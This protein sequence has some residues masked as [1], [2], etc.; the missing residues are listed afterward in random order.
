MYP[1]PITGSLETTLYQHNRGFECTL[2][3]VS[4]FLQGSCPT[5]ATEIQITNPLSMCSISLH[6]LYSSPCVLPP[7][8]NSGSK[9]SSNEELRCLSPYGDIY[10]K[11]QS[12]ACPHHV[13]STCRDDDEQLWVPPWSY[14]RDS[15]LENNTKGS[16]GDLLTTWTVC[17]G[18]PVTSSLAKAQ[19][20]QEGFL[21]ELLMCSVKAKEAQ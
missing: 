18:T 2:Q 3:V 12:P 19:L 9:Q 10:I 15:G 16:V 1:P 11:C 8:H 21:Q 14:K 5:P 20:S 17:H 13:S 4:S 7:P 6:V